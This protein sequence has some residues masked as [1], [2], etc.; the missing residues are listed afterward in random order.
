MRHKSLVPAGDSAL[1]SNGRH[2]KCS[3]EDALKA[4]KTEELEKES[5]SLLAGTFGDV[6]RLGEHGT[7]KSLKDISN[8]IQ[9]LSN[10][11]NVSSYMSNAFSCPE[12]CVDVVKN[13][14]LTISMVNAFHVYNKIMSDVSRFPLCFP[15]TSFHTAD[16]M[17]CMQ[18]SNT[19][20]S[21]ERT[22]FQ[23]LA[24]FQGIMQ[25][26]FANSLSNIACDTGDQCLLRS[27]ENAMP[28]TSFCH[29][30]RRKSRAA[31]KRSS[32][33]AIDSRYREST[34][35]NQVCFIL[36]F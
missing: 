19:C 35:K 17:K 34:S 3:N 12:I 21:D 36:I 29:K 1:S 10:P 32:I 5:A 4:K 14:A 28:S 25:N 27:H 22:D 18:K 9:A 24:W 8:A 6:L 15:S 23:Q 7:D 31:S 26:F 20:Q 33:K 13:L 11:A 16:G 2:K 30:K